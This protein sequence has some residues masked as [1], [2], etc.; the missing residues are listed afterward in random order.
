MLANFF[1]KSKPI[2]FIVILVFFLCYFFLALFNVFSIADLSFPFVLEKAALLLFILLLFF[3]FNFIVSKNKLT[4]DNS[5]AFLLFVV[6][7][8]LF[9]ETFF[10]AKVLLINIVSFFSFRKIYSLRN[11]NG[12]FEKL[13][14]ASFWIGV[15]F[16]FEPFFAVFFGVLYFAIFL[17]QKVTFR[18]I[19]IPVLG[20]SV[21]HFLYFIY[22]F[23]IDRTDEFKQLFSWYTNYDLDF[24]QNARFA[25]PLLIFAVLTLLS[26]VIT[27]PRTLSIS[28]KRR[29]NYLILVFHLLISFLFLWLLKIRNGSELIFVFFPIAT[30]TANWLQSI[31]NKRIKNVLL[32][33]L[34]FGPFLMAIF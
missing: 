16:I 30:I 3:L 14:D 31:N 11:S 33:F 10:N 22:C 20:F 28:G 1:D 19:L 15:V 25:I 12:I 5:Y 8:G 2:N 34:L 13:F 4:L 27:L 23:L 17:F 7:F 6:L 9:P 32:V 26:L 18:T 21:P 24:Y 29:D